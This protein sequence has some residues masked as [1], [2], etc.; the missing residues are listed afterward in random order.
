M[1]QSI[2][3]LTYNVHEAVG[4]DHQQD[5]RRIRDVILEIDPDI[6]NLQEVDSD[7]SE[8]NHRQSFLFET[9]S[10][11]SKYKGI[12]GVMMLRSGSAYGNAIF[13]KN[14]PYDIRRHDITFD[15]QEPRGVLECKTR[16][17]ASTLRVM[18]THLGLKKKER[19][20]QLGFLKGLVKDEDHYPILLSG[21]FNEWYPYSKNLGEL[22]EVM[23]MVPRKRS[24]PARF[25]LFALDRIFYKGK[26]HLI[27][28]YIHKSTLSRLASDH[29]PLVAKFAIT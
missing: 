22:I 17:A 7:L 21:D 26:I 16:I 15:D 5:Y 14:N 18:N 29:L 20:A 25:P 23:N 13:L 6:I 3:L 2:T 9:I 1:T 28:S 19:S 27:D 12:S 4:T 24:F 10:R 11:L 8:D